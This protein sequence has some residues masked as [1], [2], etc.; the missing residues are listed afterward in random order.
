MTRSDY[1]VQEAR[2]D[3]DEAGAKRFCLAPSG[4][5]CVALIFVIVRIISGRLELYRIIPFHVIRETFSPSVLSRSPHLDG[6]Q[7][8]ISDNLE[9]GRSRVCLIW[10]N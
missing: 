3:Y 7:A 2:W 8:I 4:G 10:D 9:F 6:C 1:L 5:A